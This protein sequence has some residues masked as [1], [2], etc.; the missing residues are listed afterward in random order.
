MRCSEPDVGP[1]CAE[2]EIHVNPVFFAVD[3][4]PKIGLLNRAVAV[5]CGMRPLSHP[6]GFPA[7]SPPEMPRCSEGV[8]EKVLQKA[9]TP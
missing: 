6:W 2:N 1:Q 3:C 7:A 8:G 9:L 4:L 5:A